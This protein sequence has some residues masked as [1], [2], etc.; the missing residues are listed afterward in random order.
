MA[1]FS[2][3]RCGSDDIMQP[4]DDC[5]HCLYENGDITLEE[6]NAILKKWETE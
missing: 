4:G 2:C 5:I 3:N 1:I 6:Y